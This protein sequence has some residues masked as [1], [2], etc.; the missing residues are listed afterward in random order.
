M[1]VDTN[2][3][4]DSDPDERLPADSRLRQEWKFCGNAPSFYQELV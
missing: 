3:I 4:S 1:E 2:A